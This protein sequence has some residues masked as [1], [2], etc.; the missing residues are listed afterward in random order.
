MGIDDL[1]SL[2]SIV[3]S[4]KEYLKELSNMHA[5]IREM[6]GYFEDVTRHQGDNG[7][8][9][10]DADE[11]LVALGALIADLYIYTS[12]YEKEMKCGGKGEGKAQEA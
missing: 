3:A 6:R 10:S 7:D 2:E 4:Q 8:T 5:K 12:E 1:W 11:T 9:M